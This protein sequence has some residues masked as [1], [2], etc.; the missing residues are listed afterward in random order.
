MQGAK[1]FDIF[2]CG[3][4]KSHIDARTGGDARTGPWL[5]MSRKRGFNNISSKKNEL[6]WW[7]NEL[8]RCAHCS[9]QWAQRLAHRGRQ[10]ARARRLP[11][12]ARCAKRPPYALPKAHQSVAWRVEQGL[13][14][15]G[16]IFTRY[17]LSGITSCVR[18]SGVSHAKFKLSGLKRSMANCVAIRIWDY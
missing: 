11:A 16:I 6:K 10:R 4:G 8:D 3:R 7:G 12:R 14:I 15:C 9:G 1:N 2:C 13:Y 18:G 5:Y 17:I